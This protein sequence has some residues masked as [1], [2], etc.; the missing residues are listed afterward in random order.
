M[1]TTS[2]AFLDTVLAGDDLGFHAAPAGL[3]LE[4]TIKKHILATM[5]EK[6]I[7]AISKR[8]VMP[9][10]KNFQITARDGRLEVVSSD[11]ELTLIVPTTVVDVTHPGVAVFPARTLLDLI[12]LAADDTIA[13]RVAD[14]LAAVTSGRTTWQL[15][16]AG[17]EDYPA[18]PEIGD[19]VYTHVNRANFAQALATCR[20]AVGSRN[21]LGMIHVADGRVTACDGSRFQQVDLGET[22]PFPFD[23]PA[24]AVDHLLKT[25][26]TCDL[27]DIAIGEA[28][29]RLIFR[30]GA[31]VVILAKPT[32]VYP[33]VEAQFLRPSLE[34]RRRL[35]VDRAELLAALKRVSVA[36]DSKSSAAVA[37]H[38]DT[39]TLTI[40]A[41]DKF[42]NASTET[43]HVGWTNGRRTIGVNHTFLADLLR[44]YG[45]PSVEILL[46]D[47]T[48]RKKTALLLTD[49]GF[50]GVVQQMVLDWEKA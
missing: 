46:G 7:V 34:N 25:L 6:A 4:F 2:R 44:A 5:L 19:A 29:H 27:D 15:A 17:G 43:L 33:D 30:L 49:T 3:R 21:S 16:L 20:Y 45:Q 32:A 9:V 41:R 14:N 12:N 50:T 13:I 36:V 11:T 31:D 47:D 1:T 18:L 40:S 24:G 38:L 10:L 28:G 39:D 23:L 26:R 48:A 22:L 35:L 37:L 8:D 42:H